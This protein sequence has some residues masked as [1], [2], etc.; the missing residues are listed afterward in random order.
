MTDNTTK[1]R[2]IIPVLFGAG[3]LF[4]LLIIIFFIFY[5]YI[6]TPVLGREYDST[7]TVEIPRGASFSTTT[8]LLERSGFITN[9]KLFYVL[10]FAKG[11]PSHIRRGEYEL[12]GS[13]SPLDILN[14]LLKGEVKGYRIPVPEG[15]TVQQVAT[16]LSAWRL[17]DEDRFLNLSADEELLKSLSISGTSVEG[18]LFPDTYLLTKLMDESEIIKFMVRRFRTV[19]TPDMNARARELGFSIEEIIILA[20]IIEKE[21]GI[22]EERPFISAV[23]HNRLKKG[24]RLQSDPTVIY[25]LK[26]FDGNLT[27]K[28]LREKTPYNTY[29]IKGLPPGPICNPGLESIQAA[30]HPA[31]IDC[32]YFVSKNNGTH[33][34]SSNLNDH[35]K[36]VIKYQI[37]RKR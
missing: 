26:D 8:D 10:A 28:D 3:L 36:A 21:G 35:N 17:V 31:P 32:L 33:H 29:R 20:S 5:D 12:T 11:A 34:F 30:L 14:K 13:M 9:R 6:Y 27:R 4:G 1:S 7:V 2:F 16:R 15:F 22:S 37:K 25:G 24:M 23:F 18:Y 19:V